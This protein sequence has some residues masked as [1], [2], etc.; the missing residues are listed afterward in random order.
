MEGV[1]D[2]DDNRGRKAVQNFAA[3]AQFPRFQGDGH[4]VHPKVENRIFTRRKNYES[5]GT[6]GC[7]G[8]VR[9][10][11][12]V[13]LLFAKTGFDALANGRDG[14]QLERVDLVGGVEL[15]L[16]LGCGQER[17]QILGPV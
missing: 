12:H 3:K 8:A 5:P 9:D 4:G 17:V 14:L 10:T 1:P 13:D 15:T 7:A 16:A 11:F 2:R 6:I